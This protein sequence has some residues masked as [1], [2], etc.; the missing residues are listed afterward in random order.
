M[1]RVD[2]GP[3]VLEPQ[4]AAHAA[5]MFDV[6]SDPAIYEFEGSPPVSMA[7]LVDRYARLESRASP[8]G[9]ELWLNWVIRLRSGALAGY[10]QATVTSD[11]TA[12]VAYQLA[13]KFW[14]QGIGRA[15]VSAMI[16]ELEAAYGVRTFMASLKERN[17][18]SRGLLR[19]LGFESV[20]A[21][22]DDDELVMCMKSERATRPSGG[23]LAK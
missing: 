10:V 20:G 22:G 5:E 11:R 3:L 14:R 12:F 17:Y 15:A 8:D 7:W 9:A 1:N 13:S 2:A 6:L 19:A 23:L 4:V 21:G 16:A 18:R